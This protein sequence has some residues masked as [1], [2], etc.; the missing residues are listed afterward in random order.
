VLDGD[1]AL[2]RLQ[3][4]TAL[5]QTLARLPLAAAAG[6]FTALDERFAHERLVGLYQQ[7]TV[8]AG[9]S[10][11][12][13]L[14]LESQER[15][16]DLL[17]AVASRAAVAPNP[18]QLQEQAKREQKQTEA[19]RIE[20]KRRRD[21][22]EAAAAKHPPQV[23][24][25]MACQRGL[26]REALAALGDIDMTTLDPGSALQLLHLR[27]NL[28]L[29]TG[30]AE[31]VYEELRSKTLDPITVLPPPLQPAFR[32]LRV[33][34]DAAVGDYADALTQLEGATRA[35]PR[36]AAPALAEALAS[37]VFADVLP[38]HPLARLLT[39]PA[40]GGIWPRDRQQQPWPGDLL[41]VLAAAQ[42]QADVQA[43]AGLLAL[44]QGDVE[45]ARQ[46]LAQAVRTAGPPAAVGRPWA[47]RGLVQ[48]WLEM[49]G[50]K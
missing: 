28:M 5:R 12:L 1:E 23:R 21:D 39:V 8:P 37:L 44:E 47:M 31:K 27:L 24:A 14:L 48:G 4:I 16:G 2:K 32:E 36:A 30:E 46:G 9:N 42:Q 26:V 38:G 13:D 45:R 20:V 34:T 6:Q 25:V 15:A 19:L 11:P 3:Q 29:L 43:M 18:E 41:Q 7:T 35:F 10:P 50:E 49:L 40:W 33:Q 22:L 17:P